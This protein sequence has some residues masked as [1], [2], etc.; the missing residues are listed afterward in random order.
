MR[1]TERENKER[2]TLF[3]RDTATEEKRTAVLFMN[4]NFK[5]GIIFNKKSKI[6]LP[7]HFFYGSRFSDFFAEPFIFFL[8]PPTETG[9]IVKFPADI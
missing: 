1:E 3:P 7:H 8:F 4:K 6:C 9:G 5:Y 2:D